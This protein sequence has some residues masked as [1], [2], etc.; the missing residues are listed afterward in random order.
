MPLS[1]YLHVP[2]VLHFIAA[3]RPRR[4]LDVGIGMGAYGFLIRQYFDVG[5]ERLRPEDWQ[6]H[7][8]GVEIFEG[9]QNPVWAYAYDS[10]IIGD[11]RGVV[12]DLGAYDLVLCNDVLEHL[13]RGEAKDL[14]KRLLSIAPVLIAT[15]PNVECPQG[16]W[17][18]NDAETHRSRLTRDDFPL[19][20]AIKNT[21]IT[22]CF[23]CCREPT[24][25]GVIDR[26][27]AECPEYTP[28]RW[29]IEG[30]KAK[31]AIRRW[32][33]RELRRIGLRR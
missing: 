29:R 25:E 24:L 19:V 32:G 26:A 18:G 16:A 12:A 9:Y 23:V 6:M 10:V 20:V 14:V 15:T 21:G 3:I 7:I 13:E 2:T 8:D 31:G 30:Q 28:R 27:S 4:L 17:L 22:S 5:Y 33:G 1:N 11:I